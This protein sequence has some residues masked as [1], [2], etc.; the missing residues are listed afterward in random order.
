M[1]QSVSICVPAVGRCINNCKTCCAKMHK[2][3]YKNAYHGSMCET[4][5]YI[6]DIRT[7]LDYCRE[8]G[9]DV[10]IL[11]GSTEPQQDREF[12]KQFYLINKSLKNPFRNLEMQTTGAFIDKDMLA[13]L[14]LLGVQTM[15]IS[16]FC[17]DDDAVNRYIT[18]TPDNK[19]ILEELCKNIKDAGMSLRVCV[20]IV[21]DVL[22]NQVVPAKSIINRCKELGADQITFR[23]M[24]APDSKTEQGKYIKENCYK[25]DSYLDEIQEFIIK[26]GTYLNTLEYGAK[27]YAYNGMSTVIDLDPQSTEKNESIKYYVIRQNGKMYSDWNSPASLVF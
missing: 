22:V 9:V 3:E 10:A 19:L 2:A 7:R 6:E 24:W 11:T 21:N 17:L 27:R 23:K 4:I 5:R 18:G 1:A 12:L 15:A 13:F 26:N 20:N 14:R 8:K 25:S 16:T